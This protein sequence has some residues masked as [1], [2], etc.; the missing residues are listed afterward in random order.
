MYVQEGD[1]GLYELLRGLAGNLMARQRADHTLQPT[2]LIHEAWLK[3]GPD[4]ERW[5][6]QDHFLRV[7]ARAMRQVLV[8]HARSRVTDK[9]RPRG[10]RTP[11]QEVIC[12]PGAHAA[13]VLS[14][15]EAVEE[16]WALDAELGRI[17]E[18]RY[19]AGLTLEETARVLDVSRQRVERRWRAARAWLA[20]RLAPEA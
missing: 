16:L 4:S 18:L 15:N 10:V 11:L 2:A 12:D 9:R 5:S 14:L 13:E 8:D 3:I 6:D 19:F 7:A 1:P 17:V 20:D